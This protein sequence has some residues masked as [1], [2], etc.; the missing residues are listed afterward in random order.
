MKLI[1]LYKSIKSNTEEIAS[2]INDR[3]Q[4]EIK[5]EER[6]LKKYKDSS[7]PK[8]IAQTRVLSP[9]KKKTGSSLEG[10]IRYEKRVLDNPETEGGVLYDGFSLQQKLNKRIPEQKLKNSLHISLFDRALATWGD[11]GRWH[12]RINILGQPSLI[13][14]PGLYEAPAK[15]EEYYKLKRKYAITG[16]TPPREVLE[17]KIQEKDFLLKDDPRTTE[18]LKGI[19]LQAIDFWKTGNPFCEDPNCRLYNA[20]KQVELIRS[21][22]KLPGFCEKHQQLYG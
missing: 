16:S 8:D 22:L 9:Y 4:E 7:L 19:V 17:E 18:V 15:P 11:D 12:K 21:Q 1:Y 5:I 14:I 3:I 10:I 20:H 2:W 6:F 13:S